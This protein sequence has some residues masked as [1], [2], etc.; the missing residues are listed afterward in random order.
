MKIITNM[1]LQHIV[2]TLERCMEE[3]D[4]A[5][6]D[7]YSVDKSTIEMIQ[8]SFGIAVPLLQ[9]AEYESTQDTDLG[10]RDGV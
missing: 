3:L 7:G 10:H 4:A 2:D 6:D 9:G 8:E 5:E 1:E